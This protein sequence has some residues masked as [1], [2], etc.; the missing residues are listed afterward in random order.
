MQTEF[1]TLEDFYFY[2]LGDVRDEYWS[3]Y[4]STIEQTPPRLSKHLFSPTSKKSTLQPIIHH[5]RT[6][7][8][9]LE[10]RVVTI[11]NQVYLV[12]FCP[13]IQRMTFELL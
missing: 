5:S 4:L 1:N 10:G 13:I 7:L 3:V 11:S 8:K 6:R 2:I 12:D 9:E